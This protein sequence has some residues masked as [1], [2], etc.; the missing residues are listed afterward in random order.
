MSCPICGE[1]Y[2]DEGYVDVFGFAPWF[3]PQCDC[4]NSGE[5]E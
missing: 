3:V 4:S 1:P 2:I 5:D